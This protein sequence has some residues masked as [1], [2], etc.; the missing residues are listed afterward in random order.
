[1]PISLLDADGNRVEFTMLLKAEEKDRVDIAIQIQQDLDRIGIKANLQ[2]LAF[3]VVLTNLNQRRWECYIGKFGSGEIDPNGISS[4][5]MSTREW[6]RFNQ[7]PQLGEPPI[8]GWKVSDWEK[9]IDRLFIEGARELDEAK[10]KKIYNKFQ[11]VAQEQLPVI[12]LVNPLT[13]EVVRE[14]VQG[15]KFSTLASSTFW[16]LYELKVTQ[17]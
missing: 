16:N 11:Q 2:Q 17:D 13:F 6:H 4:M 14:C 15:V 10:R 5:W 1:M 8:K 3:N 9:E 12:H 7:G